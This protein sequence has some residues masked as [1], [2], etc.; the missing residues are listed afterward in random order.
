MGLP[1]TAAYVLAA[2]ILARLLLITLGL[3]D[4]VAHLFV[5]YFSTIGAITPPVCAAVFLASGIADS[6]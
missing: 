2:S 4:L 3:P 1:P 5:F 6:N